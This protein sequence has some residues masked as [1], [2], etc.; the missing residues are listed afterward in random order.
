MLSGDL[1]LVFV[2]AQL[3]SD[4]TAY[5]DNEPMT[6]ESRLATIP[7]FVT[8]STDTKKASQSQL[9]VAVHEHRWVK[10]F[11]APG[12]GALPDCV[13]EVPDDGDDVEDDV[14]AGSAPLDTVIERAWSVLSE[15]CS[16]GQAQVQGNEFFYGCRSV[17]RGAVGYDEIRLEPR[18][19]NPRLLC[20][21][22]GMVQT[23]MC[24][25]NTYRDCN[26]VAL[27]VEVE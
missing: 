14:E 7:T 8:A 10:Q 9:D 2:E 21:Q 17:A 4:C 6:M 26:A 25:C 23:M 16:A 11:L 22:Y 24:S 5:V 20:R 27:A 1:L 13:V 15:G 3:G 18:R 19:G 12:K